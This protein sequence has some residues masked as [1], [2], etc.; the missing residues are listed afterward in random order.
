MQTELEI[1]KRFNQLMNRKEY[2]SLN[3]DNDPQAEEIRM[4]LSNRL[5]EVRRILNYWG[6]ELFKINE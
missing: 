3:P 5:E 2:Y 6:T 4:E 1:K